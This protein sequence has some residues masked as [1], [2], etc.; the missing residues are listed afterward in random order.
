LAITDYRTALVTGASSGIG[1]ACVRRLAAKGLEVLAVA[2]RADRLEALAKETGCETLVLD[3]NDTD[4][5]Y[6]ELGGREIDVLVNNAGLGRGFEGFLKSTRQDID[7]IL[8]VNV[9]AAIHVVRAVAEGMAAR[10]RGH[11][12]NLG[13]IAGLYPIGFPVYGASKG[14]IH[15]FQ[16]HLRMD[17]KGL[18]IRLTEICPGRVATEFFD[19][20]IKTDEDRRKFTGGFEILQPEDIADAILYAVDAPWRVNVSTIE[21]TPTEQSPGGAVIAPVERD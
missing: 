1:A 14:A 16:Q 2:R 21:L 17:L 13:S 18:G 7:E 19:A 5:V 11:I 10:K 9:V 4:A 6:R 12:V 15:L 3:V 8:T 20:A